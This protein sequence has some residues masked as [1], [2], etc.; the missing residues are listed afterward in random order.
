VVVGDF[1]TPLSPIHK[2]SKQKINKELL[3]LNDTIDEMD[4]N[5]VYRIFHPA[6]AQCTFFSEPLELSPK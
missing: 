6:T 1:N 5:D 2:L 4:L 3:D